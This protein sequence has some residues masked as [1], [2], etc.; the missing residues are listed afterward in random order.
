M[1]KITTAIITLLVLTISVF[2]QTQKA[3]TE[4]GRKVLLKSDGTWIYQDSTN[5]QVKLDSS[6]CSN[7]IK[8]TEDRVSGTNFTTIKEYLV[9]SEDGGKTGFGIDLIQSSKKSIIFTIK[10]VGAKGCI[11]DNAKV[12]L[13]FTDGTRLEI[14]TNSKFNCK[15]ELTTYFG[16]VFGRSEELNDLSSKKIEIMRVWTSNGYVEQK[17][18]DLHA[19]KFKNALNCLL[20]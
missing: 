12:N 18:K 5:Q 1:K 14:E 8:T 2:G 15:G 19:E 11:D 16:G 7:W 4:N 6:N 17:F 13:L 10:A 20:R 9:I 3:T